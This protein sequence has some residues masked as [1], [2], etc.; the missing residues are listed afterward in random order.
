MSWMLEMFWLFKKVRMN[1]NWDGGSRKSFL[2]FISRE[3]NQSQITTLLACLCA[4]QFF[5][6]SRTKRCRP[7]HYQRKCTHG[8]KDRMH[9]ILQ[10]IQKS[11]KRKLKKVLRI[12]ITKLQLFKNFL[13]NLAYKS[14]TTVSKRR[15]ALFKYALASLSLNNNDQ[16]CANA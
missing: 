13:P 15:Q 6:D 7:L 1:Y 3:Q 12:R 9:L 4:R 14:M 11:A 10:I 8:F 2:H 5:L 16:V